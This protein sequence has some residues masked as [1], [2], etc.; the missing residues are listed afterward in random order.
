M[1]KYP[2]VKRLGDSENDGILDSGY[3]IVKEK[4][5][6][7]NFRFTWDAE[8]ERI[9]FGSRNVE[10]WNEKDTDKSFTH[11]V[12]YVREQADK[13]QLVKQVER[14]DGDVVFYGEAMHPHT[15]EYQ[16]DDVPSF[17]GFDVWIGSQWDSASD[18][19]FEDIGLPSVPIV[20]EGEADDIGVEYVWEDE[21][22][23]PESQYRN[24]KPEGVVIQNTVTGQRAKYRTQEFKEKHGQSSRDDSDG[25]NASDGRR[26]ART[27]TT[28]ARVLKMI[29]KY[30]DRG[31]DIE[32]AVMEDLWRDIFDDIIDEEYDEIFLGNH[33]I[34][35]KEFRSE[36]A[37][38][39]VD[40]LQRYLSR[41]DGSVL[42]EVN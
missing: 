42:N 9:V 31:R 13:E 5:D 32:M 34:D 6:G 39:T 20:T 22:A 16:W 21:V 23:I 33:V 30:E 26:L 27:Y 24:G 3:I 18:A 12:D 7:A 28:E 15:L 1:K 35:T 8:E 11:A 14:F 10:W 25:Y 2:K 36:V 41:P 4:M 29:H 37:S 40:T 17:L 38:L 19:V